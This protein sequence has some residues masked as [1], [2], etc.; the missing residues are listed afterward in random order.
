M[1]KI[2][3]FLLNCPNY[4]VNI[5]VSLLHNIIL[6]QYDLLINKSNQLAVIVFQ[7]SATGDTRENLD[8]AVERQKCV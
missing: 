4:T 3:Y 1:V 5:R 7:Q 2:G 8:L 6:W